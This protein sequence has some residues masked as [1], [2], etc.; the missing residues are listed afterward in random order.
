MNLK[1]LFMILTY[2]VL[3]IL[4]FGTVGGDILISEGYSL[5][6]SFNESGL[7]DPEIDRGGLF[8]TG[9]SFTRWLG[10]MAFGIGLPDT[11]PVYVSIPIML[12]QTMFTIFT[13]GFI[14]SSI[15]NG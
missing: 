2:W 7:T 15:W 6:A 12:W 13:I 8:N 3:F 1:I 14:V 5:T 11:I 4:V 9:V 10:F